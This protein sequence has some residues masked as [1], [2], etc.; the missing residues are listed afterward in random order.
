MSD[1]VLPRIVSV[2][3]PMLKRNFAHKPFF[4]MFTHRS[5]ELVTSVVRDVVS[6]I[7]NAKEEIVCPICLANNPVRQAKSWDAKRVLL[8][9]DGIITC[10]EAHRVDIRLIT[11]RIATHS[12]RDCLEMS[13]F[14]VSL[15]ITSLYESVVLIALWDG[16]KIYQAGSGFIVNGKR[17]L[18]VSAAHTVINLVDEAQFGDKY[19]GGKFKYPKILIGVLRKKRNDDDMQIFEA[20]YRY[21][22]SIV[23]ENIS[24]VDA[25][26]L[27]ITSKFDTDLVGDAEI[28]NDQ[29]E[30]PLTLSKVKKEGLKELQITDRCEIEEHVR[31]VGYRQEERVGVK[32]RERFNRSIDFSKGYVREIWRNPSPEVNKSNRCEPRKE[33]LASCLSI[34]GYSGGPMVNQK[35]EVIGI[36]RA[37]D[38]VG[39]Q[40][41]VVPVSEFKELVQQAKESIQGQ[42]R[43]RPRNVY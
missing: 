36:V 3:D 16:E 5:Y 4:F 14:D 8:G 31:I 9:G 41:Y 17:G 30:T 34:G 33:I 32:L 35:G 6:K 28:L 23:A 38:R 19:Y 18:I 21:S 12:C 10:E 29:T 24:H 22:A 26:V 1:L 13:D 37:G 11:G 7:G 43:R 2:N 42:R 39:R 20:V 15:P 25:C 27:R 40:C